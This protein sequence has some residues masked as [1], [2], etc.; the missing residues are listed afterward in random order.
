MSTPADLAETLLDLR[1]DEYVR[2]GAQWIDYASIEDIGIEPPLTGNQI[3]D[4]LVAAAAALIGIRRSSGE[5][6]WT[7][8][9][10]RVRGIL[11]E[12]DSRA[13]VERRI[14][15]QIRAEQIDAEANA[16][17]SEARWQKCAPHLHSILLW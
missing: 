7:T 15:I 9:P 8:A 10:E 13:N 17:L 6:A 16:N 1:E 14:M 4:A 12:E 11:V 2:F 5:P 3:V